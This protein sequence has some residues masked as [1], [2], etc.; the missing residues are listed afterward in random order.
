MFRRYFERNAIPLAVLALSAAGL[1]AS[2]FIDNRVPVAKVAATPASSSISKWQALPDANRP[3]SR[4]AFGS[5]LHQSRP[6]PI[7]RAVIA[8]KPELFLMLGDNVYGDVK[9]PDL[10]ELKAAYDRQAAHPDFAAARAALP[11]LA[12]WDDHDYGKN[13]GGAAFRYRDGAR[14]LFRDFWHGS[15]STQWSDKTGIHYAKLFGPQGQRVQLI[16]LDTRSFRSPLKR[17]PK[18]APGKGKYQPDPDPTKTLLG[19]SQWTWLKA[20]LETPADLRIIA[21]SIQVVADGHAWERWGNLPRER[22]RLYELIRATSAQGVIFVS[23]DRHRAAIYKDDQSGP[24]PLYEVTSSSMNMAF[25][26][27]AEAGPYQL[28]RMY[29][30]V[31][32]GGLEVNWQQ[33]RLRLSIHGGDGRVVRAEDVELAALMAK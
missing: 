25:D 11:M 30:E 24:Y 13:D 17:R 15:G 20:Q 2:A 18:T 28:D 16:V 5:C 10:R 31:N 8:S 21:S 22:T 14:Q 4:I 19:A 23:G 32:S 7:W 3:L 33:R 1:A 6:Q 29:G 27:P 9:S 12:I 26:D